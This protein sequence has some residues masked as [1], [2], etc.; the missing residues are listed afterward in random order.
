MQYKEARL[1]SVDDLDSFGVFLVEGPDVEGVGRVDF[2]AW[3]NQ[4]R[5][6]FLLIDL[7]PVD[8]TEER[9]IFQLLGTDQPSNQS[10]NQSTNRPIKQSIN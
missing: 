8:F 2:T 3:R 5:R 1:C 10:I 6:I 9:V 4:R 7:L